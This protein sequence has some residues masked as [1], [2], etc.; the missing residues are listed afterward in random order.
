MAPPSSRKYS[1]R[2]LHP[3]PYG[4]G[5]TGQVA[6]VGAYEVAEAGEHLQLFSEDGDPFQMRRS[7][8]VEHHRAG[9]LHIED[10]ES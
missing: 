3:I 6:P 10:W 4:E 5:G 7:H 9:R 1:A 8:A 2:I